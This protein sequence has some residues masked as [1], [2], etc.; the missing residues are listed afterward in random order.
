MSEPPEW[1]VLAGIGV[2]LVLQSFLNGGPA[3]PWN[4]ASFTR[5]LGALTGGILLYIAWYRWQFKRKGLIPYLHMWKDVRGAVPKLALAG[6]GFTIMAR[7]MGT[8][9]P[10]DIPDPML[11]IVLLMGILLLLLSA[12]AWMVTGPLDI[13]EEEE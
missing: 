5:G 4:D 8:L 13:S 10:I 12:Y 3:G 7:V 2:V 11:M 1:R 9:S 6:A